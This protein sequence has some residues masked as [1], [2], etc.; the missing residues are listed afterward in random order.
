MIR[1]VIQEELESIRETMISLLNLED[2]MQVVGQAADRHDALT[3]IHQLKPDLFIM[4]IE[5]LERDGPLKVECPLL[6]LTTFAKM[7]YREKVEQVDAE[8][9][10]P[11][12]SPS[13]ELTSSIRKIIKGTRVYS[14]KLEDPPSYEGL[15]SRSPVKRNYFTMIMNKM[16]HPAG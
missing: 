15:E 13:E 1:I 2:D 9:Y 14:P 3:L 7:G 11:K 16:K 6:V 4:G 10:L 12:D 5:M 8:G